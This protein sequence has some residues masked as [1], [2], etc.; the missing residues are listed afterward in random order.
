MAQ[1]APDLFAGADGAHRCFWCEA[2]PAYQHY[3][4]HEWGFPVTDERRLFEKICLEGFQ[5]GLS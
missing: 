5:A 2:T 4:D 1:L 3:H